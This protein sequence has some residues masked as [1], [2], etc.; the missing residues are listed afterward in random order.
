MTG[1]CSVLGAIV[2]I[3]MIVGSLNWG[4]V[5]LFD[6]N[7]VTFLF[8]K[9]AIVERVVYIVVGLAGLYGIY[10]LCSCKSGCK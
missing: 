2:M 8:H 4:L 9:V 3:L 10:M 6:F 7:L 5:G 1:K